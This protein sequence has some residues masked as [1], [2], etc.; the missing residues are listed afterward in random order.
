MTDPPICGLLQESQTLTM[1]G[2]GSKRSTRLSVASSH[3]GLSTSPAGGAKVDSDSDWDSWDE[4]DVTDQV[5]SE[6]GFLSLLNP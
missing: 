5:R 2:T 3:D 6:A 1:S 4:D